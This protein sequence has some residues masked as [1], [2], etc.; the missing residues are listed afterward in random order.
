MK[1]RN[2]IRNECDC[3]YDARNVSKTYDNI[4]KYCFEYNIG[5]EI[6]IGN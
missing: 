4:Y 3:A 2:E 6:A 5:I 1:I